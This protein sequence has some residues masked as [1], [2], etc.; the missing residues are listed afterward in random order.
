MVVYGA[1]SLTHVSIRCAHPDERDSIMSD[2]IP[3]GLAAK[4]NN[5]TSC[6]R[7]ADCYYDRKVLLYPTSGICNSVRPESSTGVRTL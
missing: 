7:L 3:F 6:Q 4:T 5:L 1:S 2:T